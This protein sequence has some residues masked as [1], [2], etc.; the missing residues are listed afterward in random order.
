MIVNN[1]IDHFN[2]FLRTSFNKGNTKNLLTTI[3]VLILISFFVFY[4]SN[5]NFFGYDMSSKRSS[6]KTPKSN[7]YIEVLPIKT[8]LKAIAPTKI[9]NATKS[10][11][12]ITTGTWEGKTTKVVPT[13]VFEPM[14][15]YI[16]TYGIRSLTS[17]KDNR[18]FLGTRGSYIVKYQ[19][20]KEWND[21]GFYVFPQKFN[22]ENNVIQK[23]VETTSTPPD[24]YMMGLFGVVRLLPDGTLQVIPD[25]TDPLGQIQDLKEI[26]P[27]GN[28]AVGFKDYSLYYM[29]GGQVRKWNTPQPDPNYHPDIIHS[30]FID[31]TAGP[32]MLYGIVE[33]CKPYGNSCTDERA[34]K[35]TAMFKFDLSIDPSV[36]IISA[37]VADYQQI[38]PNPILPKHKEVIVRYRRDNPTGKIFYSQSINS[39]QLSSNFIAHISDFNPYNGMN[40]AKTELL[41]FDP[42]S[43]IGQINEFDIEHLPWGGDIVWGVGNYS[44]LYKITNFDIGNPQYKWTTLNDCVSLFA[45][46]LSQSNAIDSNR[47]I[48]LGHAYLAGQDND[49]LITILEDNGPAEN[50]CTCDFGTVT[51]NNCK[52]SAK[53]ICDANST[54]KCTCF[55]ID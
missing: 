5:P 17:L 49:G 33:F 31:Q 3:P 47:N 40:I 9:E 37:Q 12:L 36:P 25:E 48:Y 20:D 8:A 35:D 50:T 11:P 16:V 7:D 24:I 18:L 6:A 45:N 2:K 30:M 53:P 55:E 1:Y 4:F 26:L 23:V 14:H 22:L 10:S 39:L 38:G 19:Q 27:Y 41:P 29:E 54:N 32:K 43:N 52:P 44:C 21:L 51:M 42:P 34:Y 15:N 28:G 46:R 13:A